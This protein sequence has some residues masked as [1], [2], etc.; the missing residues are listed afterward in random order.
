MAHTLSFF[1]YW[2]WLLLL[3][4]KE[5]SRLCSGSVPLSPSGCNLCKSEALG[6]NRAFRLLLLDHGT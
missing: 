1:Q 2:P 3:I 6:Y 5:S 4:T